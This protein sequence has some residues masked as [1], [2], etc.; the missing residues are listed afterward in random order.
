MFISYLQTRDP[1]K[2][3]RYERG[4][5]VTF[6]PARNRPASS[7]IV[8]RVEKTK[9][10]VA[11]A[12]RKEMVLDLRRPDSFDVARPRLIEVTLGDRILIRA[13]NK[14]LGLTDGQVLTIS[15]IGPDGALQTKEGTWNQLSTK[16]PQRITSRL[17]QRSATGCVLRSRQSV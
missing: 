9:V 8:V 12:S 16:L 14:R 11:L 5:V 3:L 1:V 6:A 4:Q 10:V 2:T 15:G 17:K 13:N 7:A